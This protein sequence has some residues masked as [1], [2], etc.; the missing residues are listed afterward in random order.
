MITNGLI[1]SYTELNLPNWTNAGCPGMDRQL[2]YGRERTHANPEDWPFH[3]MGFFS[4]LISHKNHSAIH[5]VSERKGRE[6]SKNYLPNIV[7][8]WKCPLNGL[9]LNDKAAKNDSP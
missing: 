4:N 1:L 6:K 9:R 2:E 5:G 7:P 3:T 8:S